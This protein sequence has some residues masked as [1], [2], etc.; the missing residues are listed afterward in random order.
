MLIG[1][2]VGAAIGY[3]WAGPVGLLLGGVLGFWAVQMAAMALLKGR[4]GTIR[5]QF[6]D[7]VFAVMGAVAKADGQINADEI[8]AAERLFEQ[9]RLDADQRA[10]AQ[11]AFRRGKEPDFDLDAEI[12]AVARLCRGQHALVQMFLQVQ[13]AAIAAD[14]KLHDTEH[15]ILL[16]IA[17]GLG[18]SEADIRQV[19]ALFSGGGARHGDAL[20]SDDVAGGLERAYSILDVAA[21]ASDAEIKKAYR[22]Q[23]S[24]NHPDKL[25]G[26]GLPD[27]MRAMA[28]ARTREIGAAY[29]RIRA[30]RG[31]A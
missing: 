27:N 23:M 9:L 21:D 1:A 3:L 15:E 20:G 17:R 10:R 6:L 12:A 13:I 22:R 8:A 16:H 25:A 4:L 31:I 24:A 7:H 2:L 26:R 5:A 28:E 29:E 14:G 19:E 18:L 30:A 11:A